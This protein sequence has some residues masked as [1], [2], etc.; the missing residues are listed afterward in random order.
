MTKISQAIAHVV[1]SVNPEYFSVKWGVEPTHEGL[2]HTGDLFITIGYKPE[3]KQSQ[4]I[5]L[6]TQGLNK[7]MPTEIE[8]RIWNI[9][10]EYGING[11]MQSNITTLIL[12]ECDKYINEL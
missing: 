11:M 2:R 8:Q 3:G 1:E 10:E 6:L 4:G 5:K 7:Q 9:L 12:K